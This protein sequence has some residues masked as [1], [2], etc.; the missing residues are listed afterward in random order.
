MIGLSIEAIP[1]VNRRGFAPSI[2]LFPESLSKT[3][4]E[5][6]NRHQFAEFWRAN[7]QNMEFIHDENKIDY[8]QLWRELKE[9][10][11]DLMNKDGSVSL[12]VEV[13]L[14]TFEAAKLV[15]ANLKKQGFSEVILSTRESHSSHGDHWINS[16]QKEQIIHNYRNDQRPDPQSEEDRSSLC[17]VGIH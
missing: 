12:N 6:I 7:D 10:N 8:K 15:I 13:P 17:F 16:A 9:K 5:I 2:A 3:D 1:P 4:S 14:S 11:R